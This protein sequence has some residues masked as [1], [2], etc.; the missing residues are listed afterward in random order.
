MDEIDATFDEQQ[1]NVTEQEDPEITE[2]DRLMSILPAIT[3]DS[4]ELFAKSC[5]AGQCNQRFSQVGIYV[6][7]VNGELV[8]RA[9]IAYTR[10]VRG[11]E[12]E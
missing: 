9:N 4:D 5:N 8:A 10:A 3:D 1:P 2:E 12:H 7:E 6:E 11:G